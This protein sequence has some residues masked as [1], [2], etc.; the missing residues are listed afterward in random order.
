M[1]V[2]D[3]ASHWAG[4][5]P[6]EPIV[7]EH[8]GVLTLRFDSTAVQSSMDP[9]RPCDL[10]LEYSHIMISALLF[11][12][13]PRRIGMVGLGGGSLVK[14]CRHLVPQ[15]RIDVAEIAP[16]VIALRERFLIPP[17]DERLAIACADGAEWV[18]RHDGAFDLLMV[19]GFDIGG[20]VP[21]LCTQRFYD[22]CAA[23]LAPAG[24]LIINLHATDPLHDAYIT[25]VRR[26]FANSVRVVAT[27]DSDNLIVFATRGNAFRLS[28]KQLQVRARALGR[29]IG[30]DLL[31][32]ARALVEGRLRDLSPAPRRTGWRTLE[33]EE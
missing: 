23:A 2:A 29:Q 3:D 28:E 27:R 6:G 19:D 13:A 33:T 26:S 8:D 4:S 12:P 20:Q 1:S 16:S 25:R 30:V 31:W 32:L 17:D 7:Q 22:D 14:A 9:A 24:I 11:D 18:A 21:A 15:A 5:A 10:L